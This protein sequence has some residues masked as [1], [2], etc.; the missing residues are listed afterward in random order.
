MFTVAAKSWLTL[1]FV[2][3]YFV[4][5]VFLPFWG[6]W[7]SGQGISAEDIGLLF[8]V[9]LVLRF[10]SSMGLL[11]LVSSGSSILRLLRVLSFLTLLAFAVLFY[12][13]GYLWLSVITL[14][15][16]FV[17]GP[18]VPLGDII[19][20]R[21]VNQIQLDYGRVRLWGSLSFIAGSSCIGWLIV[22]YGQPSILWL[23]VGASAVMWTVSLLKLTPQL[24]DGQTQEQGV[25]QSLLSLLKQRNVLLFLIVVGSIQGSHGAYYAF[26]SIYWKGIGISESN[27]AWL[28]A[29][30]VAA[31]VLLMRFNKKLFTNWSIKQMILLGLCAGIARWWVISFTDNVY[32]LAVVQTFHAFTF[33]VTHLAAIRY[34]SQQKNI[35]MVP[36]QTLYSGVA[37]GLLMALFTYVSGIFYEQLQGQVFLIMSLLL[38][39][40]LWCLKIWKTA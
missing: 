20:T 5:G 36:Y 30:A 10:V 31:E 19:G 40:V 22:E 27:I 32:L 12:L 29:I 25:K 33:A 16:N 13:Q 21:L 8:S 34:I 26:S 38:I 6:V 11:P 39:P 28:W 7:L 18:L 2:A 37:L 17:I 3:F 24:D 9:G 15:I 23:I 1:Y 35:D 14:T 4:W